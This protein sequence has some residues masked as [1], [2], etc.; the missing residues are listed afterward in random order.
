MDCPKEQRVKGYEI[1]IYVAKTKDNDLLSVFED[2]N[3]LA[4][5]L[6]ADPEVAK[7]I[8][9]IKPVVTVV[10]APGAIYE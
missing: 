8:E 2:A 7:H 10:T 9:W 6:E 3:C 1:T 5:Y 4:N